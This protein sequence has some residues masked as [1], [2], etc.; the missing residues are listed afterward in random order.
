[1]RLK[2][3]LSRSAVAGRSPLAI[4]LCIVALTPGGL[5]A[6]GAGTVGTGAHFPAKAKH[7]QYG[8]VKR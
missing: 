2:C 4:P 6:R 3:C 7:D 8:G 1:M 5:A